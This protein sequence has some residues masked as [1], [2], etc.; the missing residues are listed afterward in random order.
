MSN[1][2]PE[3]TVT[4]LIARLPGHFDDFSSEEILK[5][6]AVHR[7]LAAEDLDGAKAVRAAL[8]TEG[9]SE[10]TLREIM[11][12][13]EQAVLQAALERQVAAERALAAF[14]RWARRIGAPNVPEYEMTVGEDPCGEI[15]AFMPGK[16]DS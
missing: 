9:P 1:P 7:A 2:D 12:E 14:Y 5:F 8:P 13:A 6:V 11:T 16:S 3:R 4:D 15:I 10:K